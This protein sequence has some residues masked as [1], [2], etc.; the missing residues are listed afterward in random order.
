MMLNRRVLVHCGLLALLP[1]AHAAEPPKLLVLGDSLSAEY[2]LTRGSGW[3]ALLTQRLATHKPPYAVVNASISGETTA[4]GRARL[5]ALLKTHTPRVV[6]IALGSNDALRGLP[7]ADTRAHLTAM[8]AACRAAGARVLLVGNQV[9]PNYGQRYTTDF[10]AAFSDVA[11]AEQA[12][13]VPFMLA[14]VADAKD[15]TALFQADRLHPTAA[16]QPQI[17]STVWQGL[18]PLL[19]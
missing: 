19:R 17:L 15:P 16:A 9:P 13:L 4:G 8:V 1:T 2:G 7:L 6:V 5:A 18:A 3:V 14:G 12:A 11:R 10:A